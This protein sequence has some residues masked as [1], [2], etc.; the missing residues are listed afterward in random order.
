MID[1]GGLH[2]AISPDGRKLAFADARGLWLSW[3]DRF[4]PPTQLVAGDRISRPFWSPES[5]D[6]GYFEGPKLWR[7]SVEGGR[8]LA[9][10]ALPELETNTDRSTL[11]AD[12]H[13]EIWV[14]DF[15]ALSTR[16][17]VSRLGGAVPGWQRDGRVDVASD[18]DVAAEDG[19]FLMLHKEDNARET[20]ALAQSNLLVVQ[21]WFAEFGK[22]K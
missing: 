15:P 1:G 20:N 12:Q 5:T 2:P 10:A 8:P 19:R 3:L 18:Y 4:G 22:K 16:V 14:V 9:M 13:G 17:K 7:V 6:I 11:A 21:N